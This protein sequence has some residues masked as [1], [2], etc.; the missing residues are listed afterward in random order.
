MH[1]LAVVHVSAPEFEAHELDLSLPHDIDGSVTITVMVLGVFRSK[2][3]H[4]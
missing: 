3:L 4:A 2:L 1:I